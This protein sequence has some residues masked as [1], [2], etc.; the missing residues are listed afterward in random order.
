MIEVY[1]QTAIF[2]G[3]KNY[4]KNFWD[5]EAFLRQMKQPYVKW[6]NAW[7][8]RIQYYTP[9]YK[10]AHKDVDIVEI[11]ETSDPKAKKDVSQLKTIKM[12]P[13]FGQDIV[14]LYKAANEA[15]PAS[16]VVK[17]LVAAENLRARDKPWR[18]VSNQGLPAESAHA[19]AA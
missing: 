14:K 9:C 12:S 4:S 8:N 3:K 11:I 1:N 17:S 6:Q 2:I 19:R 10:P 5:S 13:L 15:H 16:P 7:K 18:P